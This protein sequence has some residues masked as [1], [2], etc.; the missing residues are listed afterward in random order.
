MYNIATGDTMLLQAVEPNSRCH[1]VWYGR[2]Q[3]D[4]VV[5]TAQEGGNGHGNW[6]R[7]DAGLMP[8]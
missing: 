7:V 3:R 4:N 1:D 5:E 6:C 8:Y 2:W